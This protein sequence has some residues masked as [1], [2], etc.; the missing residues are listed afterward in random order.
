MRTGSMVSTSNS[1]GCDMRPIW[2][3]YG[4]VHAWAVHGP[5]RVWPMKGPCRDVASAYGSIFPWQQNFAKGAH[6]FTIR[7][8]ETDL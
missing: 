6:C 2:A 8:A 4:A 7:Q 1:Q 5:C 3:A